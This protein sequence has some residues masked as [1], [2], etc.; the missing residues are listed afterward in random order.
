MIRR[1]VQHQETG[2][3]A[4][5]AGPSTGGR[6]DRERGAVFM[7]TALVL[8]ILLIATSMAVDLGRVRMERRKLQSVADAVALDMLKHRTEYTTAT[9]STWTASITSSRT[10]NN[11]TASGTET[12]Q[13]R[14]LSVTPGCYTS[15]TDT[16]TVLNA[17]GCTTISAVKVIATDTIPYSFNPVKGN[18]KQATS[19]ESVASLGNRKQAEFLVGSALASVDPVSSSILGQLL[20]SVLPGASLISYQGLASTNLTL[21]QLS[22]YLPVTAGSP[23]ELL[24]TSFTINQ[25][26][27]ASAQ[28]LQANGANAAQVAALYSLANLAVSNQTI[29]LADALNANIGGNPGAYTTFN[30]QEL[31]VGSVLAVDGDHLLNLDTGTSVPGISSVKVNLTGIEAPRRGGM[32]DG[33]SATTKQLALTITPTIDASLGTL[34]QNLCKLPTSEQNLINTLLGGVV[35]LL[36]CVLSPL[37]GVVSK[38]IDLRVTATP[39][40]AVNVAQVTATQHIDC[41]TKQLSFTLDPSVLTLTNATNLTVTGSI[42][43]ASLGNLVKVTTGTNAKTTGTSSLPGAFSAVGTG[44]RYTSF[45]PSSQTTGSKPLG[46]AALIGTTNVP[47]TGNPGTTLTVLNTNLNTLGGFVNTL[48]TSTGSPLNT[49]LNQ[50]DTNVLDPLAKM[51]GLNLGGSTITPLDMQCEQ[52]SVQLGR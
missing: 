36:A 32:E 24:N 13:V 2:V 4:P 28:A 38:V 9:M 7:V 21:A 6:R 48:L 37:T 31:L 52:N 26:A 42:A 14:D 41:T 22:T 30:V 8:P 16:F 51:L 33:A 46:L 44:P 49:L 35:N 11:F 3:E 43:G 18:R 20:N 39:S 27:L 40:I 1:R 47:G 5:E 29:K 15:T 34:T 19:R 12:D 25:L 45:T 23:D 10:R 50:L 17:A